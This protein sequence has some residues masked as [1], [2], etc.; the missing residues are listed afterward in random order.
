MTEVLRIGIISQWY[1]PEPVMIPK[2]LSDAIVRSGHSSRIITGFPNY[3]YGVV[4]DGFESDFPREEV[5]DGS[6]VLRVPSFVSHDK[7]ALRRI[8]SFLSFAWNSLRHHRFLECCDVIYVYGTPMTAAVAAIA[9]RIRRRVP[10]V[11]HLQDLWPES[12]IESGMIESE[13][14]RRVLYA[15]ISVVLGALYKMAHHIVVISPGMK[16]ALVTRGVNSEK[17]SVQMNWDASE[18][19]ADR[20]G[21]DTTL[22]S[23]TIHCVYAGNIGLMQDVETIIRAAAAVQHDIPLKVSIYG[24]GVAEQD[25]KNLAEELDA[26]NVFFM[27]RVS[28]DKMHT[29][30]LGSH[31]QLVTL[32]DRDVFK[33]TIPSKFQASM[34]NGIPVITTVKGDLAEI[35]RLHEIGLVAEPENPSS[36]AK[37]FHDA[38]A[39]G[40]SGRGAMADRAH[41]FYWG[42]MAAQQG[43]DSIIG[44]LIQ[45]AAEHAK[46]NSEGQK[47]EGETYAK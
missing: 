26:R 22:A 13:R 43:T 10:F 19:N 38:A 41:R 37:A 44:R 25:A 47:Y 45:A 29:V 4:Y 31:F 6:T 15:S 34:S 8:R 16:R 40:V 17:I 3:P 42:T 7:S 30:Y 32:K 5:L 27:G 11:I 46:P 18:Q 28:A 14:I 39:L 1:A 23:D 35:C 33:M 24:S 12:V 36:L 9:L 21:D 2:T 20:E